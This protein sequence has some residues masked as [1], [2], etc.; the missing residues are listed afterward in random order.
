M[1]TKK[2]PVSAQNHAELTRI[3]S[4]NDVVSVLGEPDLTPAKTY[5]E[6]VSLAWVE[7]TVA[8]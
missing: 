4:W 8:G 1:T 3:P 5:E 2:Q 7:K 6:C